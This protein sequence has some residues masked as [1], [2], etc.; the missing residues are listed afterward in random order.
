MR[1]LSRNAV[2]ALESRMQR[3]DFLSRRLVHPGERI[4][5]QLGELRH[6]ATG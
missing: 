3:L 6:L 2:R 5:N 1:R 4:R